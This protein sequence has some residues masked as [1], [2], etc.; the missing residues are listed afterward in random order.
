MWSS[1]ANDV[2]IS[3]TAHFITCDFEQK[4]YILAAQNMPERHTGVHCDQRLLQ[5]L[6]EWG[7]EKTSGTSIPVTTDNASN[8]VTAFEG[9]NW[10]HIH[11]VAYY[12]LNLCVEDG[13]KRP[14]VQKVLGRCRNIVSFFH[15]SPLATTQ[16][17]ENQKELQLP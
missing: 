13:V 3:L 16:L 12:T 4:S 8:M 10:K 11:C 14:G 2:Y 5:L 9:S 15:R 17:K 7:L 1:I 6:S